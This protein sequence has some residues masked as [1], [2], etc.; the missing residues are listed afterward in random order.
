MVSLQEKTLALQQQKEQVEQAYDNIELLSRIGR[1]IAAK[2]SIAEIIG[3]VYQNVNALMDAAVF[4]IGLYNEAEARL[5]FPATTENGEKLPPFSYALTDESRL[6]VVCYRRR[7][8]IVIEDMAREHQQDICGSTSRRSR[9]SRW[10][11]SST[12][13]SS[14]RIVRSASSR[15]RASGS[16]RSPTTT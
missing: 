7:Q 9:A 5:D 10:P 14:S 4:G 13:R 16:M 8:E 11:R 6:A 15:P 3:T 1:D 12:C 2:L